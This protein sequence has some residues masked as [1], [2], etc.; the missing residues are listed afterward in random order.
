MELV[1]H[2]F[3]IWLFRVS[4]HCGGEGLFSGLGGLQRFFS[5]WQVRDGGAHYHCPRCEAT[6]EV[7]SCSGQGKPE[8]LGSQGALLSPCPHSMPG[9]YLFPEVRLGCEALKGKVTTLPQPLLKTNGPACLRD[10]LRVPISSANAWLAQPWHKAS[11][12][13]GWLVP[14]VP[15]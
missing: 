10:L 4:Q 13:G 2:P 12:Q 15:G 3:Y 1:Q 6:C 11:M 7:P 9:V 8:K 14:G 5:S